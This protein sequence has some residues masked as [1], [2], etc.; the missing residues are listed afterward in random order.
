M[1]N[2]LELDA[3]NEIEDHD[4]EQDDH[5]ESDQSVAGSRDRK[6]STFPPLPLGTDNEMQSVSAYCPNDAP[7]NLRLLRRLS[8]VSELQSTCLP[9]NG[10]LLLVNRDVTLGAC[11]C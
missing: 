6:H 3:T 9:L 7:A 10:L 2:A 11:C 4:H 1:S 5:Q 8:S